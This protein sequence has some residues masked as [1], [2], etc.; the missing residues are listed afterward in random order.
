MAMAQVQVRC[1]VGAAACIAKA[2]VWSVH[3]DTG[4]TLA[5]RV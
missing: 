4:Y 2:I 5:G 1:G 3:G